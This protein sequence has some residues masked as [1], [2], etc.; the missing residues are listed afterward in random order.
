MKKNIIFV[1]AVGC[2]FLFGCLK[3]LED[4]GLNKTTMVK[5]VVVE[6]LTGSAV[7]GM[8]IVVTNGDRQGEK[9]TTSVDGTF[10]IMVSY[11]QIHEGYHLEFSSDSLYETTRVSLS[12]I[13]IGVKEYDLQNI[14]V[15]GPTLPIVITDQVTGISQNA[16]V[17]GGTVAENGRSHVRHRGLCWSTATQPT[18][19]NDH[20]DAGGGN[21]H[22][23][24]A[25]S[26]LIEG[27]TYYVRSYAVNGVG[28][29]Y[30]EEVTFVTLTGKP[31]VTTS[32]VTD[33][34]QHT[35]TCGGVVTS[36]NG[37]PVTERG[38]CY[39]TTSNPPSINDQHLACGSGT[40]SFVTTIP[41]LQSGT[42]YYLRAYATNS[43]GTGY[44][45]VKTVTTF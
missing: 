9:S 43:E 14:T 45:E 16:A 33:I 22:F 21:G 5:G 17:C 44:G 25:I 42:Q 19:V 27:Q 39:S 10:S 15:K 1:I 23:T 12:D 40:G 3:S 35:I 2:L 8:N 28:T 26:D 32:A 6:Q 4:E 36:D 24:V 29:A 38:I 20:V 7:S 30:G 13:G 34:T 41:N 18:L 31:S 37:H 11:E